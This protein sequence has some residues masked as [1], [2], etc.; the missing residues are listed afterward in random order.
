[1]LSYILSIPRPT[2]DTVEVW[3]LHVKSQ[4]ARRVTPRPH[5]GV[6]SSSHRVVNSIASGRRPRDSQDPPKA[7]NK[8]PAAG[9]GTTFGV[10]VNSPKKFPQCSLVLPPSKTRP[11][12]FRLRETC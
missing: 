1:M 6:R 3:M 11:T 5:R 4:A 12:H 9:S 2:I 10:D 8:A 7:A